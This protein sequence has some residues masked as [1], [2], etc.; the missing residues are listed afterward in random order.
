MS[1]QDTAIL[2]KRRALKDPEG[3]TGPTIDHARSP[4]P[5]DSRRSA[6]ARQRNMPPSPTDILAHKA[7]LFG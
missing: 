4:R 7:A 1:A 6:G 2:A 3:P 5:S